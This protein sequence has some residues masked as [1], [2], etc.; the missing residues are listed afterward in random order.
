MVA[1]RVGKRWIVLLGLIALLTTP[2]Y[3]GSRVLGSNVQVTD[4]AFNQTEFGEANRPDV[5][6][7]GHKVYAVWEDTRDSALGDA[8]EIY[9]ARSTDGGAT[10]SDNVNISQDVASGLQYPAIAA[11]AAGWVYVI[12]ASYSPPDPAAYAVYMSRS[13]DNGQT[14]E[15]PWML[16]YHTADWYSFK[17]EIAAEPTGGYVYVVINAPRTSSTYDVYVTRS[18]DHGENWYD[19]QWI[20]DVDGA[21]IEHSSFYGPLIS[22][23]ANDSIVCVAWEDGRDGYMRIYGDCSTDHGANWGTDFAISPSGVTASHPHLALAPDGA[24]YAAY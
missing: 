14:F 24:L 7:N 9:F 12:W 5:A 21:G 23:V 1:K 15:D 8:A 20:N 3:A 6:V 19:W 16:G 11:D 17:P 13:N 2:V 22:I 10:W 4:D 18:A